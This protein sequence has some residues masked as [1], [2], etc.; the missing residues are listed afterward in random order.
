MGI[1]ETFLID[2]SARRA[3][4]MDLG[5]TILVEAAAGT[6]KTTSLVNRMVALLREGKTTPDHL[7][8]MTF[9]RKASAHLR[10]LFQLALERAYRG[11]MDE[12]KRK[13]LARGLRGID[14]P[15]IGTIHSFC[16]QLL[17]E[18]PLEAGVDPEFIE[19]EENEDLLLRIECWETY[20]DQLYVMDSPI[21]RQLADVGLSLEDLRTGYDL[22]CNYP[23]VTPVLSRTTRPP[24]LS[25]P[26]R[27]VLQFMDE[28]ERDIPKTV[29]D[30]G[31]DDL[32]KRLRRGIRLRKILDL[33]VDSRFVRLLENL[34]ASATVIKSRWPHP[35]RA[36][37]T[38]RR[39]DELRDKV[40]RP[41][42]RQ[43][44]EF[45][46]PVVMTVIQ[47]AAQELRAE[48]LA[49]GRLNF[50]D[51]LMIARDMLRDRPGV[52]RYL[53]ERYT[54]ILVDEFQDTDPIQA[55][56]L[57]YLTG[58]DVGQRDW[59]KV[60]PRPGALFIVGDPKQSIYRFRRADITTYERVKD[61]IVRT[62]G[63][64]LELTTNFRSTGKICGWIN[65]VFQEI[66]PP[67]STREQAGRSSLTAYRPQGDASWGVFKLET[68]S[69]GR[70]PAEEVAKED[71]ACIAAWIR[72]ALDVGWRIT[73]EGGA[74]QLQ[75]R[76][77]QPADFMVIS[78][79]RSRL[80]LY[81]AA[82]E[83]QGIPFDISGGRSFRDSEELAALLTFLR[84]VVDP[85]D[86]V[87][88]ISFLRGELW[89][90]DDNAL[91]RFR[92]D[93]GEF[94]Y[95]SPLPGHS[96]EQIVSAYEFLADARN[97]ARHLPPGAALARMFDRLGIIAYGAVQQLGDT[98][99][100]NLL[101]ALT[102]A[103][104]LS[105]Q[106]VSFAGVVDQLGA[107]IHEQD[108]EGMSAQPGQENAVRVLNLHRAKGLEAPIVFLADPNGH[109]DFPP[110]FSIDREREPPTG[111]FLITTAKGFYRRELAR[112][113]D[114]NKK[115]TQEAVFEQAEAD[116]LLYVAAT[117]AKNV[118]VVSVH[119]RR[120][121]TTGETRIKGP[122]APLCETLQ[123]VLHPVDRSAPEALVT[124]RAERPWNIETDRH[125]LQERRATWTQ[126]TYMV[127]RVTEMGHPES[128]DSGTRPRFGHGADFGNVVHRLLEAIMR[129][130]G[131]DVPIHVDFLLRDEGLPPGERD[132]VIRLVEN[133]RST[134]LWQQASRAKHCLVEVP[135]ALAVPG[136]DIS[137][138]GD[139][140]ETIVKGVIDLVFWDQGAWV[141]V[142][143][144]S[145]IVG[146]HLSD[147]VSRYTSQLQSYRRYWAD[148][149]G[150]TTKAALFFLE[151][152]DIVW[153]D[154]DE[155]V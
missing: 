23:D 81:G 76:A 155:S 106:G 69:Q 7:A 88:L 121:K 89:G 120:L 94:C 138:S 135:F 39:L 95:L 71:A 77:V 136:L 11:A 58:E 4:E 115:A 150:Q 42:L 31:W 146:E 18:R 80:H 8:T 13:R 108:V 116:R 22:V 6:G 149:T 151:T 119:R 48:R 104:S 29:P 57:F 14:R 143:Y 24:D 56:V 5:T 140:G 125:R 99:S 47:S 100:G 114:W 148:L 96:D 9:T 127:K 1:T 154:E 142:D 38:K 110:V 118:L 68:C 113:P 122:W 66:F 124:S 105:A 33:D 93:G 126:P 70:T 101:K 117:R 17:H 43:W 36:S 30:K 130:P 51:L 49:S 64:V 128:R 16:A 72:W 40:V 103:R 67:I 53:Q 109:S 63:R 97:W 78:R 153:V 85:D 10:E 141:I 37:E 147:L 137:A 25:H 152:G 62:G 12:V 107:V 41:A 2:E 79:H 144:K 74:D 123:D 111:H 83:S 44:R 92:R 87:A 86:P 132:T 34:D 91:Y 133:A 75:T 27:V 15:F 28:V 59:R 145:D 102:I 129:D 65:D 90:I 82:L 35:G 55:E 61:I 46:Y 131:L 73:E 112:P 54:H 32:Q 21:I 60:R 45:L 98:R 134:E 19:L 84:A 50:Q 52:R 20:I 26:R 3:I 139:S